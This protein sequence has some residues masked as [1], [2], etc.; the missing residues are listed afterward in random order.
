M[1]EFFNP[2]GLEIAEDTWGAVA[3]GFIVPRVLYTRFVGQLSAELGAR[4][5]ERLNTLVAQLPSLA[6]FADASAL[7]SYDGT[8]RKGFL[9]FALDHRRKLAS[10]VMLT[11][12][13]GLTP[14]SRAF[15]A[16]MGEPICLLDDP[17]EFDR[18]LANLVPG[19]P[20]DYTAGDL[21]EVHEPQ[22]ES[23]SRPLL[24]RSVRRS[25]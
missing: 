25:A 15:A 4:Y 5:V 18:L 16:T 7:S 2:A 8:A 1:Q 10:I 22:E 3:Y 11:W 17:S 21:L 9:R 14:S 24:P 12:S 20:R 13:G 19:L 23:S 6:Y